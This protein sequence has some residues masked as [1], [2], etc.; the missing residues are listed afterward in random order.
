M[1]KRHAVRESLGQE[2]PCP[3]PQVAEL[4]SAGVG[5]GGQQGGQA[6]HLVHQRYVGKV[7]WPMS[8]RVVRSVREAMTG[9]PMPSTHPRVR[10]PTLRSSPRRGSTAKT[11]SARA[12]LPKPGE[13]MRDSGT[14]LGS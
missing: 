6:E 3:A 4:H 5:R 1:T 8:C 11:R 7:C 9:S 14:M 13:T 12:Y 10:Q 2:P